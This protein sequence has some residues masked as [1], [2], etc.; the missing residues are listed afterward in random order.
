MMNEMLRVLLVEDDEDYCLLIRN[1]LTGADQ[2]Q[3]TL[4]SFSTY[5]A[6]L[7]AIE[8]EE[9]DVYILDHRLGPRT[10]LELL[11]YT[12]GNGCVAPIIMLTG[13]ANPETAV[14]AMKAGAAD[15]LVKGNIDAQLLERTIR[16]AVQS[17]RAA[18]AS[19]EA[20]ARFRA[21]FA[22]APIGMALVELSAERA[23]ALLD[24]NPALCAM[25]ERSSDELL[26][27][28]IWALFEAGQETELVRVLLEGRRPKGAPEVRLIQ[29]TGERAWV[30]LHISILTDQRGSPTHAIAQIVDITHRKEHESYLQHLAGQDPLTGLLNRR[31]F[32][33]R[34]EECLERS[35][36]YGDTGAVLLLDLNGFKDV[37][38]EF[39][40]AGGDELLKTVAEVL[41][42]RVRSTD[43][44][45]KLGGA[46][47]ALVLMEA[48]EDAAAAIAGELVEAVRE[49][50]GA[51]QADGVEVTA[52][53]GLATFD[54][55]SL[56]SAETLLVS[57]H[58]ALCRAKH[59]GA[60]TV[61][62]LDESWAS[63]AA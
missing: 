43:V 39:R 47:F 50:T 54:A 58:R 19:R 17:R 7:E 45:A 14:A 56:L 2:G 40:Q 20:E 60:F 23:G 37:K 10:G 4:D 62:S 41:R 44:L 61:A 34:L 22:D 18:E 42:R 25:V 55:G 59:L 9:H 5:E 46:E 15:Y 8:Q 52:S 16:Y 6:G 53:V 28:P 38:E 48:N 1:L 32:H 24:V 51:P 49:A 13:A 35:V 63:N 33:A 21:A 30:S 31:R 36:R 27:A 29:S 57:A 12:I 11:Q 3:F 26:A